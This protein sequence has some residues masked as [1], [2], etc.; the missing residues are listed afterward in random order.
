MW[1]ARIRIRREK[2]VIVKATS[3]I[4]AF[5]A[6]YYMNAFKRGEKGFVTKVLYVGGSEKEKLAD[7]IKGSKKLRVLAR[8]GDQIFYE[9][10]S[11]DT[12]HAHVLDGTV[13]TV[14]PLIAKG[15][16]EYWTIGSWKKA[17]I[18]RLLT[19]L[20]RLKGI[21]SELLGIRQDTID[22]FLPNTFAALS[23]KER[24]ALLEAVEKGYYDFPRRVSLERLA[25]EKHVHE[26]TFREQLRKAE[27]KVLRSASK[28]A[29][30]PL[31]P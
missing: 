22:F 7:V 13:F 2:S 21:A 6:S 26:S 31:S 29:I 20:K 5:T 28:Q 30:V 25:E 23:I 12:F 9:H 3:T 18:R 24:T 4:N 17:H 27:G 10:V 11:V 15:G 8:E 19:K 14:G 16:A 1:V